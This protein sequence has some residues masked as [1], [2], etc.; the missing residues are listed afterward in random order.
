[1][2]ALEV[3]IASTRPGRVGPDIGAWF[4][5]HAVEHGAFEVRVTDLAT[6]ALPF[7]DEPEHPATRRYTQ[8]HTKDWSRTVDAADAF[9][10]VVPEYNFGF[11]APV[12]NAIDYLYHEWRYKPVGFVSYGMGSAGMR[13]VQML[14]Q[15]VTTLRMVP[16]G[17]TVAIPS[18]PTS[19]R[20]A[21]SPRPRPS[22]PRPARPST[23]WPGSRPRWNRCGAM[24]GRDREWR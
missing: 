20:T 10:F 16:I 23:S 6:L 18:A 8:Q 15:V 17:D 9:A 1:M 13:A 11:N 19:T 3:I 5:R 4:A 24:P 14:K 2:P 22:T 12:K 7:L 21:A